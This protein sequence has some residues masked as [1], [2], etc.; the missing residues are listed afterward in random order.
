MRALDL[1]GFP[2]FLRWLY[3][4]DD[5]KIVRT[6]ATSVMD[7]LFLEECRGI[8]EPLDLELEGMFYQLG[9]FQYPKF[10]LFGHGLR[11]VLIILSFIPRKRSYRDKYWDAFKGGDVS[12]YTL[13]MLAEF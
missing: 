12:V 10:V 2:I 3:R 6:N 5:Q 1:G 4:I 9:Y 11:T 8:A 7:D 13:G